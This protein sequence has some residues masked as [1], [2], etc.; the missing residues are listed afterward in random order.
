MFPYNIIQ[1]KDLVFLPNLSIIPR[2]DKEK[3]GVA[4]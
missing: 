1:S 3:R 2:E 4:G